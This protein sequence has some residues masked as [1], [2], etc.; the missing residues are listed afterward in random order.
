[1]KSNVP[2]INVCYLGEDAYNFFV[3][4]RV[5]EEGQPQEHAALPIL[6]NFVRSWKFSLSSKHDS[7]A[8]ISVPSVRLSYDF[9]DDACTH[10]LVPYLNISPFPAFRRQEVILRDWKFVS[11]SSSLLWNMLEQI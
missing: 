8:A 11:L 1:M 9:C 3:L 5:Q 10:M 7:T 4:A 2:R 6:N